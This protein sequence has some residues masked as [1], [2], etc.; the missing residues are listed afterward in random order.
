MGL[1][2]N[3]LMIVIIFVI[4]V[5]IFNWLT[6]RDASLSSMTRADTKRVVV[7]HK[8]LPKNN[9]SDF[10]YSVW[11]FIDDWNTN[12]GEMKNIFYQ[13]SPP[14]KSAPAM[15][16]VLDPY[17]NDLRVFIET[18]TNPNDSIKKLINDDHI[19]VNL[20]SGDL[21]AEGYLIPNIPLQKWVCLIMSVNGR[22]LDIYLDGK[23]VKTYILPGV[24]RTDTSDD[25]ILGNST[26]L[27]GFSGWT[28]KFQYFANSSN[29]LQAYDI[30]KEGPGTSVFSNLFNKYRLKVSF[31]EYNT[32]KSSFEI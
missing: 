31:M 16:A 32:E 8:H 4:L 27:K 28:S 12:Y 26:E 11:F 1:I 10:T 24:A 22:T 25:I 21:T 17:E 30:Y 20:P 23:L 29:P 14:N 19:Q 3:I 15:A 7:K 6:G 9:S 2:E 18:H 5:F 13:G